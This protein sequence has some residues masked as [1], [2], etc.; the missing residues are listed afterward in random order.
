V[1]ELR[2]RAPEPLESW[3]GAPNTSPGGE[4]CLYLDVYTPGTDSARRPVL[5]CIHG[6]DFGSEAAIGKLYD[7]R[8]LARRGDVVVVTIRYRPGI[9]GFLYLEGLGD[10]AAEAAANAG[11][12]DQ[13]SALEWVRDNIAACGGDPENVTA[14][15]AS[16][17][18]TSISILM[19]TAR[20][21]GLFHKA[22]LQ[23]G[24]PQDLLTREAA[25][26]LTAE[27]I[28][29]LGRIPREVTALWK[30]KTDELLRAQ[31]SLLGRRARAH[32][33]RAFW[34]VLEE[35]LLEHPPIV[36]MER[37]IAGKI[38]LL[39]GTNRDECRARSFSRS[40]VEPLDT[41]ALLA[42]VA[43]IA[44]DTNPEHIVAAYERMRG[45]GDPL[46][47]A[48]L[49][50]RIETDAHFRIPAIRL[51]EART[52]H[53][54]ARTYLYLFTWAAPGPAGALGACHGLEVPFVFGNLGVEETAGREVVRREAEHLSAQ[55]MDAWLAFSRSGDP[56]HEG[57]PPWPV[58]EPRTRECMILGHTCRTERD[59]EGALREVWEPLLRSGRT[60]KTPRFSHHTL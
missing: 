4:D 50:T 13:I 3:S 49:L 33:Y 54:G 35:N 15:G 9:F 1:G 19:T 17:G 27:Y 38:P 43:Q 32:D 23:S 7:G 37:G 22:V 11:L 14:I 57:L 52:S 26:H 53:A 10:E 21:Q 34:P 60:R 25:S 16:T 46:S 59:Q 31:R 24:R 20:S 41:R 55:M 6:E 12:L 45:A 18:A 58:Y 2:F 56:S 48:A 40:S 39:I 30:L 28:T 51:A 29:E 44:P 8:A 5:V 42:R 47:P 36:A